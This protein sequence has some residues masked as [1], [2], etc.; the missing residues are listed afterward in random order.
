MKQFKSML[1]RFKGQINDKLPDGPDVYGF[2]GVNKSML[3]RTCD[4]MYTLAEK[5]ETKDESQEFEIIVLKRLEAK[6]HGSLKKFL[7]EDAGSGREKDK[8]DDF[9]D[10][11]SKLYEKTKQVYF[12]VNKDGLRDDIEIQNL[13]T[14]ITALSLIHI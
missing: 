10:K 7:D 8:F 1:T 6:L 9:L 12:I 13:R 5:I 11:F 2:P 3:M 14:Q 4:D